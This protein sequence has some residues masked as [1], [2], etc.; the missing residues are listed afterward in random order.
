FAITTI[1]NGFPHHFE[2]LNW[3]SAVTSLNVKRRKTLNQPGNIATG[4]LYFN[5]HTD[6]VSIILN[7]KN[8]RQ[9]QITCCIQRFPKLTFTAG[10]VAKRYVSHFIIMK[11]LKAFFKLLD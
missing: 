5:G 6:R 4:G 3:I 10:A 9:F 2:R 1:L 8:N 11:T 7:Q